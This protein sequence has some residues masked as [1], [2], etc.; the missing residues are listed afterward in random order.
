MA[1]NSVDLSAGNIWK[2]SPVE[3]ARLIEELRL[4]RDC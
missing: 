3:Q 4:S 1:D 2:L